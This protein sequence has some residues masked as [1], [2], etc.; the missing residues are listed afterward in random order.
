MEIQI[1]QQL[2]EYASCFLTQS[3]S[4]FSEVFSINVYFMYLLTM[5]TG[6][7]I[8]KTEEKCGALSG[9]KIILCFSR[10]FRVVDRL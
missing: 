8:L 6:R 5:I 3:R 9:K 2:S 10:C 4:Q 1:V 7:L